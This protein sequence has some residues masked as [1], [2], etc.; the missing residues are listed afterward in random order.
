MRRERCAA[1]KAWDPAPE[2][3]TDRRVGSV[4]KVEMVTPMALIYKVLFSS[5]ST[6]ETLPHRSTPAA[7]RMHQADHNGDRAVAY[8]RSS[9]QDVSEGYGGARALS[10]S[11][12]RQ[13]TL[14][15]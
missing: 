13:S 12:C 2:C 8:E 9:M 4:S 6:F 14:S 7:V 5:I 3:G 10:S 1:K 11:V 15:S